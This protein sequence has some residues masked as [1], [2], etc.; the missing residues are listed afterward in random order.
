MY[1]IINNDA[2]N[3][4]CNRFSKKETKYNMR[5]NGNLY[6][7]KPN[8][9]YKKRSLSYRGAK[10]WNSL[11]NNIKCAMNLNSFKQKYLSVYQFAITNMKF[12]EICVQWYVLN[13]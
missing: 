8:T 1:K 7:A 2:P 10:L 13:L 3:Y 12:S 9:D 6:L 4:L 11:E 5:N